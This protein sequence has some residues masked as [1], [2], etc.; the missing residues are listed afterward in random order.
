[1]EG[2]HSTVDRFEQVL[3]DLGGR[4]P[5]FVFSSDSIAGPHGG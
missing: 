2:G 3:A 5:A 4:E 1:M